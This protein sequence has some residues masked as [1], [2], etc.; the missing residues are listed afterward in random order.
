MSKNKVFK[1][2]FVISLMSLII[3]VMLFWNLGIYVD[4]HNTSPD[5]VVG[6]E[7]WLYMYWLRLILLLVLIAISGIQVLKS[8]SFR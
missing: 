4:E 7:F 8:R 3:S 6:G 1:T 2:I 5:V